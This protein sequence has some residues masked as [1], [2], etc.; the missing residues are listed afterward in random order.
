MVAYALWD[1]GPAAM[2]RNFVDY[3]TGNYILLGAEI[4]KL[5][6][7]LVVTFLLTFALWRGRRTLLLAVRQET[8][9]QDMRRFL[10]RGVAEAIT[11]S[12]DT[13]DAGMAERREA[14]IMMLDIRGFTPFSAT[15][16][17]EDVVAMLTSLHERVLPLIQGHN[18]VVD[19]FLGDGVMATFGAVQASPTAAADAVRALVAAMAEA[20]AWTASMAQAGVAAPLTVNGAVAA[21]PIVFAT[22]GFADRL[23]YTVIGEAANLAA[24]LEKHNKAE[25][26]SALTARA[27]YDAAV[28]Q[29][30]VPATPHEHRPGRTVA[31]VAAPLDLVVLTA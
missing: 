21:G 14:A 20:Q 2:T 16:P 11:D 17:P 18:G 4:D 30:Y 24:K 31:G 27:T 19:K 1:G 25:G 3:L 10:S 29:G 6:T 23:E 8:A 7:I 28:A 26:V 13:V 15:V 5:S 9:A 22:L 12:E